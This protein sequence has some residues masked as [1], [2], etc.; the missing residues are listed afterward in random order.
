MIILGT[1]DKETASQ[2][3][4][5]GGCCYWNIRLYVTK[6]INVIIIKDNTETWGQ[7]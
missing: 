1:T 5:N 6:E 2:Q 3:A 7:S 4:N